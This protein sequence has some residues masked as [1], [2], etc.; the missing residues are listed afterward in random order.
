MSRVVTTV[1]IAAASFAVGNSVV[2]QEAVAPQLIEVRKIW[3]KAPHNA[4]TDLLHHKGRW[5][6][7]FREGKKHVSPDGSLRVITSMDGRTWKPLALVSHPTDDL[8]D[9]KLSVTPDGRFMLNGA[10]M[11]A[12]K[13]IRYHSMSW[14]S[15]DLGKTW[16]KGRRI[17]DSLSLI[18]I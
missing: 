1:L 13:P 11:Q 15:S 8:R 10:G 17:G 4:F 12:D 7:V 14:F 16:D 6:C 5:Y 2:A 9:A 18:H 3:D